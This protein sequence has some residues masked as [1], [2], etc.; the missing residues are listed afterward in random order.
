MSRIRHLVWLTKFDA[1]NSSADAKACTAKPNSRSKSGSDSRTDSS[2]STT[3]TSDPMT[4]TFVQSNV[5][6][7][8]AQQFERRP[9]GEYGV[10]ELEGSKTRTWL[11]VR[12]SL[13]PT[14]CHYDSR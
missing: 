10:Q 6:N 8:P 9:S 14:I 13:Q 1:R 4:I 12:H 2:S 11:P 3:E 5:L 7:L